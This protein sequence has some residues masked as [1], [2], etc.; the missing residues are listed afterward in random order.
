GTGVSIAG[1]QS[2]RIQLS[3]SN[4]LAYELVGGSRVMLRPS[5]TEPK[6]KCYFDLKESLE[7]GEPLSAARTRSAEKLR[8]L[9][10]AFI[11]LARDRGQFSP[12]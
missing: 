1:G 11:A 4:V 8:R 3:S 7:P 9:E 12:P 10:E 2:E 6:I 5:G